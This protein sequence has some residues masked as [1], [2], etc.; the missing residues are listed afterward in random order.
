[1]SQVPWEIGLNDKSSNEFSK[2]PISLYQAGDD[3]SNFPHSMSKKN[4]KLKTAFNMT[5]E[6][7]P[8]TFL[9]SLNFLEKIKKANLKVRINKNSVGCFKIDSNHTSFKIPI[10][11][12]LLKT[13]RNM[14]TIRYSNTREALEWDNLSFMEIPTTNWDIG[15]YDNSNYEFL[16]EGDV[17]DDYYAGEAI[18]EFERAITESDPKTNIHFYLTKKDLQKNYLFS[19][20]AQNWDVRNYD[21]VNFDILL[22]NKRSNSLSCPYKDGT[23]FDIAIGDGLKEGWNIL[24]LKWAGGGQ[25]ISWDYLK[26]EPVDIGKPHSSWQIGYD[27]HSFSEFSHEVSVGDDYFIGSDFRKFERGISYQDLKTDIHFCLEAKM[28]NANY[29][30]FIKPLDIQPKVSGVFFK[31]VV[32]NQEN[33]IYNVTIEKKPLRI[34]ISKDILKEGQNTIRL[35]WVSGSDWV[36]WDYLKFGPVVQ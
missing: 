3:V 9:L 18:E 20:R 25:W 2:K 22:N 21:Y 35:E 16:Y 8:K 26:F 12:R 19:L 5:E 36:A 32:N 31:V 11:G 23:N 17:E 15:Q 29:E 7:L 6:D 24:S 4:K 1:M 34:A 30:L 27:D 14:I 33:G 10:E 28:L 13:G